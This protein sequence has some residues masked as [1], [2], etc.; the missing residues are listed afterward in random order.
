MQPRLGVSQPISLHIL[1]WFVTFVLLPP[2]YYFP[3][4]TNLTTPPTGTDMPVCITKTNL[5]HWNAATP[6]VFL[7]LVLGC[8]TGIIFTTVSESMSQFSL[9]SFNFETLIF[10]FSHSVQIVFFTALLLFQLPTWGQVFFVFFSFFAFDTTVIFTK[11]LIPITTHFSNH[12]FLF[13]HHLSF[14][15]I[16]GCAYT[17]L[18]FSLVMSVQTL[19]VVGVCWTRQ[20]LPYPHLPDCCFPRLIPT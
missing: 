16:Y 7:C 13:F 4:S 11:S 5:Q 2:P 18:S 20:S 17:R 6:S 15:G 14:F 10:C 19:F 8:R 1:A 12:L 3:P 9:A